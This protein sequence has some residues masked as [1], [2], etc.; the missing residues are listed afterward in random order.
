VLHAG[1]R[2][3]ALREKLGLT[4]RNVEAIS[5]RIAAKHQN[6][7]FVLPLSRLSDIEAKEVVPNIYRLYSLAA[8][9][10]SDLREL[11]NWYGIDVNQLAADSA[12]AQAPNS[13]LMEA[14]GFMTAVNMPV[15]WNSEFDPLRTA[16]LGPMIEKWGLVPLAFLRQ[17]AGRRYSYGYIGMKDFTMYPILLPGSFVQIDER[18][19][20]VAEEPWRSEYERPIYFVETRDGYRCCWC[21]LSDKQ[22]TLQPH[23]L[24]KEQV[25]ILRYPQEAEVIGEVVGVAM[26]LGRSQVPVDGTY[27]SRLRSFG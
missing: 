13:H 15:Q 11:L 14:A 8:I 26:R 4:V 12:L 9:Y 27:V 2:L 3:R 5:S 17:F 21:S 23:P 7:N 10:G 18:R 25:R 1:Q 24:S 6:D 16:N 20:K 19:N 22:I